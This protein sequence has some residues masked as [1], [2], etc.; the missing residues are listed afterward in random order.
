[1][2][3]KFR[4]YDKVNGRMYYSDDPNILIDEFHRGHNSKV[5]ITNLKEETCISRTL[6]EYDKMYIIDDTIYEKDMVEYWSVLTRNSD[7]GLIVLD[8]TTNYQPKVKSSN[9][10]TMPLITPNVVVRPVGNYYQNILYIYDLVTQPKEFTYKLYKY[11]NIMYNPEEHSIAQVDDKFYLTK[12]CRQSHIE[13]IIQDITSVIPHLDN[14]PNRYINSIEIN[15]YKNN[16]VLSVAKGT[17]IKES[18]GDK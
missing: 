8:E 2:N 17:L 18:E 15:S 11:T 6:P 5:V 14:L 16:K 3:R 7:L 4:I 12:L 13:E 10:T 1:M 9:R